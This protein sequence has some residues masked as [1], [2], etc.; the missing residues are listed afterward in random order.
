M[1]ITIEVCVDNPRSLHAAISGGTDRIELCSALA[2]GGLTPSGGFIELAAELSVPVHA[3]IRPHEG[4]FEYE[5]ADIALMKADIDRCVEAGLAGIVVGVTR[6]GALNIPVMAELID[7]ARPLSVTLHRAFDLVEEPLQ[8]IDNAAKL[9]IERILTS[10]GAHSAEDGIL[11]I[12]S[13]AAHA[14]D[15][16]SIMAGSGVNVANAANIIENTSI[17]ELHGS[18]SRQ[19]NDFGQEAGRFGFVSEAGLTVTDADLVRRV[20]QKL[21]RF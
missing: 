8:A 6:R 9:G 13:Y 2:V 10:G 21:D 15:R 3:M 16:L 20:K 17:R 19:S 11:Q 14:E 12:K 5:S 18:F 7:R 4:D 1:S